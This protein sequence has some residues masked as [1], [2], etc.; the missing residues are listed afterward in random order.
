MTRTRQSDKPR[1][2]WRGRCASG[3]WAVALLL[4]G[5]GGGEPAVELS[6]D[7]YTTVATSLPM[8]ILT[9]SSFVPAGSTCP[10][11]TEYIIIGGLG[12][13]TISYR[14]ETLGVD[15]PVFD[16]LWACNS[17]G[18]RVMHWRSNPISL[19][20]GDNRISVTMSDPQ[21]RSSVTVTVTRR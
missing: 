8:V 6:V 16:D 15:G 4:A 2:S 13:H 21:R 12:P 14:N 3:A 1:S 10:A 17:Q 19:A 5:C 11:S 18:G 7:D 9:G 20:H